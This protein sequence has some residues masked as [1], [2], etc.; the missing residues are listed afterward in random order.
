MRTAGAHTIA[1]DETSSVI[2][3]MPEQAIRLGAAC[4]VVNLS[5]IAERIVRWASGQQAVATTQS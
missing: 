3:G 4:E 2:F 5:R 1:Q